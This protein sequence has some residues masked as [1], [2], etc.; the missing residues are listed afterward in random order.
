ML[1]KLAGSQATKSLDLTGCRL[2]DADMK[3]I[4]AIPNLDRLTLRDDKLLTAQGLAPLTKLKLSYLDLSHCQLD[5]AAV[6][7]L[8]QMPLRELY[9]DYSRWDSQKVRELAAVLKDTKIGREY[10]INVF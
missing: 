1:K 7:Y 5:S 3:T 9:V 2:T 4:S 8:K 10:V 6:Q